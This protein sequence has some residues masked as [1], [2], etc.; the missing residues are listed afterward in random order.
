MIVTSFTIR[1]R[2]SSSALIRDSDDVSLVTLGD[3]TEHVW[4][5]RSSMT[6]R[7]ASGQ[8]EREL[9]R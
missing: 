9:A 4:N 3:V 6:K 8:P 7:P 5:T 2:M 1:A